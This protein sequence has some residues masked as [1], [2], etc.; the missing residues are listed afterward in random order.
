MLKF[1][2]LDVTVCSVVDGNCVSGHFD[3]FLKVVIKSSDEPAGSR[4]HVR[5]R[6][7]IL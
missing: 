4:Q 6:I 7:V 2:V 1:R 5:P 3:M